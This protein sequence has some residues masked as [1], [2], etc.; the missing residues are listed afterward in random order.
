M[1]RS[2]HQ[3]QKET[4]PCQG[5]SFKTRLL[6]LHVG[7]VKVEREQRVGGGSILI[8]ASVVCNSGGRKETIG[9]RVRMRSLF[10]PLRIGDLDSAS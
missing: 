9:F 3:S 6:L 1:Q 8:Y 7:G 5:D 10:R 4:R 2:F